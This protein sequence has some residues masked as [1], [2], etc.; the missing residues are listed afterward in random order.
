MKIYRNLNIKTG[1]CIDFFPHFIQASFLFA[2]LFTSINRYFLQQTIDLEP[3]SVITH[4]FPS[5]E[6]NVFDTLFEVR[7]NSDLPIYYFQN[8]NTNVCFDDKCRALNLRVYWNVTGRYLGLE[9]PEKEF[10]SKT[11]HEPFAEDEYFKLNELLSDSLSHLKNYNADDV[12]LNIPKL[13]MEVDGMTSATL[14]AIKDYVIE[15]AAYTTLKLWH[16]IHGSTKNEIE[17]LTK[18]KL[19]DKL[20]SLVLDSPI[21]FD[22]IWGIKNVNKEVE[23]S[24]VVKRKIVDKIG[25]NYSQSELVLKNIASPIIDIEFQKLL[26]DKYYSSEYNIKMLIIDKLKEVNELEVGVAYG[27]VG[28][29]KEVKGGLFINILDLIKQYHWKDELIFEELSEL[30]K[31]ENRF[32]T[33]KIFSYL[34]DLS[35]DNQLVAERMDLYSKSQSFENK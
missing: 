19:D 16:T 35:L 8:L 24:S 18:L 5:T 2:I 6:E 7:S 23:W 30:L 4:V 22:L 11:D 3:A 13:N 10:L 32:L 34:N 27:L 33:N 14:P 17:K 1:K 26:L 15:G 31:L 29:L 12:V 28:Q 9:F 21:F 25:I 20:L